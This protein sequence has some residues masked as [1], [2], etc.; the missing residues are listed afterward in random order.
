MSHRPPKVDPPM[1]TDNI[2]E[3]QWHSSIKEWDMLVQVNSRS[4]ADQVVQL[5]ACCDTDLGAKVTCTYDN[6]LL[7]PIDSFIELLHNLTVIPVAIT[8]YGAA[9]NTT[10]T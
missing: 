3:E 9:K 7:G 5:F 4:A 8:M 2:E 6:I 10:N 1:L